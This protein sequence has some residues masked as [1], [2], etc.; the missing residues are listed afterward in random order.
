M[1]LEPSP[2]KSKVIL[3]T[4]GSG[5]I[6]QTLVKELLRHDPKAIRVFSRDESKQFEMMNE[7]SAYQKVL[8]FLVGDVRDKERVRMA[9][10]GVDII[11]HLAAMKHVLISSYN[12]F[13]VMKTNIV[14]TQNIVDAAL[15]QNV[16]KVIFTSTDKAV[17]PTN[18]MGISKLAAEHLV[19]GANCYRGPHPT[20][21]ASAR[22]GNVLGSRGSVIPRFV[23]QLAGGEPVTVTNPAMTRF[24]MTPQQASQ[25]LVQACGLAR[26]GEIF[27]HKMLRIKLEDLVSALRQ[28]FRDN[29]PP[30]IVGE[31]PYE[32]LDEELMTSDE[33]LRCL[34]TDDMFIILPPQVV[35]DLIA[36]RY[37][38]PVP[39]TKAKVGTYSSS[40]TP[41]LKPA[42]IVSILQT[43]GLLGEARQ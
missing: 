29:N 22:F 43:A 9:A 35:R 36:A 18:I 25:F 7:L 5:T 11:F 24:M 39:C 38:Y 41:L 16:S 28:H 31:F 2:V 20:V 27:V 13:E 32:K 4:G 1:N 40:I 17:N 8:R 23:K 3:V 6:G 34:E 37:E 14:G 19:V 10:E 30:Q 42:E 33:S 21:F 26:G 15:S 12:P